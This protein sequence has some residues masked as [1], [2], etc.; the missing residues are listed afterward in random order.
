MKNPAARSSRATAVLLVA[1]AV[2]MFPSL[3]WAQGDEDPYAESDDAKVAE[4]APASEDGV[5]A[6]LEPDE[7]APK[8]EDM[9]VPVVRW[10][11]EP[12]EPVLPEG[13]VDTGDEGPS[14]PRYALEK[15]VIKGNKK[16][17]STVILRYIEI[18]PGE[19]FPADDPRLQRA[20]YRLLASGWF[21]DVTLSLKRGARRG[22]V[23]LVVEVKERNTIVIQ[24]FVVGISEITPYGSL[25]VADRSFLGSGVR[26][27][28][29]GVVSKEQWG[30]RL[31]LADDHFLN[32]DFGLHVEGLFVHARDFFGQSNIQVSTREGEEAKPYAVMYYDRAGVVLGA[33]YNLLIDYFFTL[34]YRFD[35]VRA[36]VPA[37]GS[38]YSFGE[39]RPIEFGHLLPGPSYVSSLILGLSRDTRDHPLLPSE[40]AFTELSVELATEVVGSDYEFSKFTLSHDTH[41]PLGRGHSI[42]LGLFAGL[43]M[44][45][46]PFFDQF[47]VGDFSA[48]IPSRV[49]GLNFAHLHPNLLETSVQEMRY[50]DLAGSINVEYSI[51]FYRGHGFFY[52]IDGFVGVGLFAMASREDLRNDPKGYQGFEVVPMDLTADIGVRVDTEIG[53]LELTF[54][55]LFRLIPYVGEEAAE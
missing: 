53:V 52:G 7:D 20:R 21:Y 6:E 19:V 37:A 12:T 45:E 4:E 47:F 54:G 42:R 5:E 35:S 43:I 46:A 32:S 55:N 49:L 24:D 51:P 26:A 27:S 28:A 41:F 22:W 17:L 2:L 29:S 16:T 48:F 1:A 25:G 18:N 11:E 39:R 50:E 10:V 9:T 34:D 23:V 31:A 38:H 8:D 3:V 44:G 15:V 14:G 36:D 30:Y 13:V 33:G 40:G